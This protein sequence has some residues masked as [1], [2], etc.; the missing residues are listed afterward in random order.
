MMTYLAF[1]KFIL[2]EDI[3]NRPLF[4]IAVVCVIAAL[5]FLTTGVLSEL[6]SRTYFESSQ[7]QQYV[8]YHPAADADKG[9]P[10]WNQEQNSAS[11]SDA[12]AD[13]ETNNATNSTTATEAN[14][15]GGDDKHVS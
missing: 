8:I 4:L 14:P 12:A 6:I 3:G 2:G 10:G 13:G 5:Q 7:R 11:R 1:V 15:S 9:E